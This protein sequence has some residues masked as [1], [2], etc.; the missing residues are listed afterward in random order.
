MSWCS[1][2]CDDSVVLVVFFSFSAF[3]SLSFLRRSSI[4]FSFAA[5]F[6][7]FAAPNIADADETWD[8]A[9]SST[10]IERG[11]IL[12]FGLS[13]ISVVVIGADA[14]AWSGLWAVCGALDDSLCSNDGSTAGCVFHGDSSF[15]GSLL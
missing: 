2:E 6:T 4:S 7:G 15:L 9:D 13:F 8:E 12:I 1:A 14:W 5:V 3:N 11:A 10:G